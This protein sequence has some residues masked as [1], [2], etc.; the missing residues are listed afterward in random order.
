MKPITSV[1]EL[2]ELIWYLEDKFNLLDLEVAGCK[3]WLYRRIEIYYALARCAGLM[4][5]MPH[6]SLTTKSRWENLW[7][8]MLHSVSGNPFHGGRAEIAVF[9]HPRTREYNGRQV[10]IYTHFFQ[11]KL[12]KNHVK[13]RVFS[14]PYGGKQ[15]VPCDENT[16]YL[17]FILLLVYLTKN[18]IP[19][20]EGNSRTVL[21]A[22]ARELSSCLSIDFD[23]ISYLLKEAG[24]FRV[25]YCLYTRLL[26]YLSCKRIY[27][28]PSYG[29]GA[30]VWAAK[31]HNIEVYEFQHGTFSRYHLGYSF[32]G[33]KKPV[34]Y[35]PDK[36]LVWNDFWK[37]HMPLPIPEKD[38]IINGF[39]YLEKMK[40]KYRRIRKRKNMAVVISQGAIGFRIAE[41]ICQN[42]R[43]LSHFSIYYKLHPGEYAQKTS[44]GYL[45]RLKGLGNIKIVEDVDLYGLLAR[46][47]YQIGVFST[48]LYEG[49]EL[50]CK[51]ILLNIPG[52][53]YMD[54][55]IEFYKPEIL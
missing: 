45:A 18:Y 26:R 48:A 50:G 35:F 51:T 43:R 55:F 37:N 27:I 11:E 17:D 5:S 6:K 16:R 10:D 22:L 30:L 2:C 40:D 53:E 23:I 20:S 4:A 31:K 41:K 15:D 47:E 33:R 42:F 19:V 14:K 49:V 25:E 34:D 7:R 24:R 38:V 54:R 9:P 21:S 39:D 44:Y 46:S 8:Y 12:K 13:Y 36:F 1:R 52:I 28:C 32:P 29:N 3:P